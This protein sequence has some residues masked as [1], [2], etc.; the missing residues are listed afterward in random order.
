MNAQVPSTV[1]KMNNLHTKNI[2][3]TH[4]CFFFRV[5]PYVNFENVCCVKIFKIGCRGE[6]P[7]SDRYLVINHQ[8]STQPYILKWSII[9]KKSYSWTHIVNSNV[10]VGVLKTLFNIVEER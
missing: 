3:V 6:A 2:H 1:G 4:S 7:V 10:Y 5:W 8:T 9:L